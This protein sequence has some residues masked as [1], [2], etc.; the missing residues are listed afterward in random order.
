MNKQKG[1]SAVEVVIAVIVISFLGFLGWWVY[2]AQTQPSQEQAEQ[3]QEQKVDETATWK[4][5]NNTDLGISFKYP[6]EWGDVVAE[7]G[8]PSGILLGFSKNY[9]VV[10]GAFGDDKEGRGGTVY[11]FDGYTKEDETY[12]YNQNTIK[13]KIVPKTIVTAKNS[14]VLVVDNESFDDLKTS[15][16]V[17]ILGS[18]DYSGSDLAGLVNVKTTYK[19]VVFI[20]QQKRTQ[21]L[22]D[23]T[24]SPGQ[25]SQSEFEKLLSTVEVL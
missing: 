15:F 19:G 25:I 22:F 21:N 12:Y 6:Q 16:G 7:P 24:L 11:D 8:A 14:D 20:N 23:A 13:D 2:Q 9:S 3:Q 5:Y 1:F 17:G 10:L 18:E 4:S